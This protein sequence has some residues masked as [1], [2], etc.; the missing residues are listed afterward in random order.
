MC[1][2]LDLNTRLNLTR[3]TIDEPYDHK[4]I[5]QILPSTS[6][7]NHQFRSYYTGFCVSR[8]LPRDSAHKWSL[9]LFWLD[10]ANGV[11]FRRLVSEGC[12]AVG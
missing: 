8:K 5:S 6:S 11:F 4:F 2:G 7:P 3:E 12:Y 9:I 10:F 1:R